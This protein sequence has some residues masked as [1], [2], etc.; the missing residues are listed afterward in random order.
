VA[1]VR[2]GG[3]I[4]LVHVGARFRQLLM[5]TKLDR[6]LQAFESEEVAVASFAASGAGD[7][8]P[9]PPV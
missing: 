5:V 2:Q 1:A 3:G 9:F 8:P 6:V 4:R 7:A